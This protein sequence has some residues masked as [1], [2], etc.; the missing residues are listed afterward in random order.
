MDSMEHEISKLKAE[1]AVIKEKESLIARDALAENISI[2]TGTFDHSDM[3]ITDVA[4]YGALH[5]GLDI[6][7]T[8]V[9]PMVKSWVSN[10]QIPSSPQFA[11][12]INNNTKQ[13]ATAKYL[14]DKK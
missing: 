4:K 14:E 3:N 8:I 2:H 5:F 7:D 11:M 9:V 13:S 10:I 1:N 6:D 12:D